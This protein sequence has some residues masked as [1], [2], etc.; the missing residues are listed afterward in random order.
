MTVH[1]LPVPRGTGAALPGVRTHTATVPDRAAGVPTPVRISYGDDESQLGELHL[2]AGT[3][4][5]PVVVVVHGGYWRA[6]YGF[7]LG[8]PLA[9]DLANHGVAAWNV[10][11]RRVGGGGGWPATFTDVAAAVD[12]LAGPVQ[13]AAGGRLDLA[14]VRAVGHS[15]GGHLAVWAAGRPLLPA[16]APGAD[17]V[18]R[19]TR[20]V[21][22]AG[23]LDLV[24]ASAE[25]LSDG[26]CDELLDGPAGARPERYALA[27]PLARL[28][29]G[30]A[31]TCVHGDADVDV[32]ISQSEG[33]VSAAAAAGDPATLLRL[34]GVDHL[35]LIDP[36]TGAWAAC[37]EAL[38]S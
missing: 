5:V 16:G 8:T 7:D 22:Q 24:T 32:P 12:A 11:Y 9:A 28:P 31:V 13:V 6:V 27:A 25:G 2:P 34:P 37:R 38:L 4:P 14:D 21:S 35:A 19:L 30:L 20:V 1:R 33:Y 17:P 15:A 10:E 26:A 18:V 36:S 23:V 3:D 29:I